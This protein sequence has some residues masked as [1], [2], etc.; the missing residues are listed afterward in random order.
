MAMELDAQDTNG[1]KLQS[2]NIT[3]ANI[4]NSR[5]QLLFPEMDVID[6]V[7]MQGLGNGKGFIQPLS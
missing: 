1:V 2:A 7:K 3:S 6:F 5:E 4:K